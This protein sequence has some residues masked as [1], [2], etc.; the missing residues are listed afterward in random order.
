MAF[1]YSKLAEVSVGS[2]GAAT[3]DFNSIPQNYTDLVLVT[4]TRSSLDTVNANLRFNQST[5]NRT[6]RMLYGTGS[7]AASEPGTTIYAYG[8]V[9]ASAR[10]ANTFASATYYIPNYASSNSKSLSIDSAEENNGTLAFASMVASL[11][12]N[13]SAISQITLTPDIGNFVQYSTATL[14]GVKAEV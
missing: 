2:G 1:T 8:N 9:N 13:P 12:S 6:N 7:A 3:I 10:T 14:Y 5:N 4:S 11:W